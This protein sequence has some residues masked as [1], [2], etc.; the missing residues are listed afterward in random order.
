VN[1]PLPKAPPVTTAGNR[2]VSRGPPPLPATLPSVG[3][4]V[5]NGSPPDNRAVEQAISLS[6]APLLKKQQELEARLEREASE[7]QRLQGEVERLRTVAT[8]LAAPAAA[9][10]LPEMLDGAR[11]GR[12][13]LFTILFV[14]A[15]V[16]GAAVGAML[17]SQS[18]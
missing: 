13:V 1:P 2:V 18:R 12:R 6:I 5:V 10:V 17:L 4:V 9:V 15:I 3:P 7:R 14:M 16:L 8:S 11:R